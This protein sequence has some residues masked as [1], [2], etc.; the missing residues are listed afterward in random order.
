MK[1]NLGEDDSKLWRHLS[2]LDE[3]IAYAVKL[4]LYTSPMR[5]GTL[6]HK[7]EKQSKAQWNRVVSKLIP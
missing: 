5:L 1:S 6:A 3:Q 7:V 4:H 2:G